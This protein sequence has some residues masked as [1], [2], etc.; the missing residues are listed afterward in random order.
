MNNICI[1]EHSIRFEQSIYLLSLQ[2][3]QTFK[4]KQ[5]CVIGVGA[6]VA[7]YVSAIGADAVKVLTNG[8]HHC[9]VIF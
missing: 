2:I 7:V 1:R 9:S 8:L 5:I 6:N 4:G 3:R